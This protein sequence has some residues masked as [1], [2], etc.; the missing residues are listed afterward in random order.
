MGART[1]ARLRDC[2]NLTGLGDG[3]RAPTD[4]AFSMRPEGFDPSTYGRE[5]DWGRALNP[6]RACLFSR[7]RLGKQQRCVG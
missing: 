4:T 6:A 3:F 5:P 2:M 7:Q 1:R